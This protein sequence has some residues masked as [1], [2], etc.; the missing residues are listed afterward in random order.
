MPGKLR[1]KYSF[2]E[3]KKIGQLGD[4][5]IANFLKDSLDVQ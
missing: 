2:Y 1:D 3:L 4:F 5:V